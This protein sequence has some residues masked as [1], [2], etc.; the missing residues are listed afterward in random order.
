MRI[1]LIRH[2]KTHSNHRGR[3]LGWGDSPPYPDWKSDVDYIGES[4][5]E[6]DIRFDAAYS[7]DLNRSRQTAQIL[8]AS[9]GVSEVT[10]I[11][12]FKEINYGKLQ[13][14][15]KSWVAKKYP[16]HKKDPD[17]VYPDGESFR[18][19]QQRS[20]RYIKR[21]VSEYPRQCIL[22]VSHAGVIRGLISHFLG[23]EYADCLEQNVSHRYIGDFQFEGARCKRYQELGKLSGFVTDGMIQVPFLCPDVS[24]M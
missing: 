7:S 9:F 15:R 17:M 18:Q 2:Y 13:K 20:L 1:I 14:R 16:L 11:P 22:L 10:G 19:M 3:I 24:G 21:L 8:A 12:E 5:H 23:L 4:L 6:A